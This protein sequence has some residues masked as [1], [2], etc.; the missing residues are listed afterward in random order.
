MSMSTGDVRRPSAGKSTKATAAD[1]RKPKDEADPTAEETSG[2]GEDATGE[3]GAGE[4][5]TG[6]K[7][8]GAKTTAAK[9]TAAKATA[10]RTAGA[11]ATPKAAAKTAP[12]KTA[13]AKAASARSAPDQA[14][15]A[16]AS[17]AGT[18]TKSAAPSKAGASS[19]PAV[20][21]KAGGRPPAKGAGGRGRRPVAPVKVHSERNW[22]PI[23]LFAGAGVVAVLI[24]GFAVVQL[25]R[26]SNQPTW[27]EKAAGIE[28]LVN[29]YETDPPVVQLK[30]HQAGSLTYK[31][32]PPAA[33]NHNARWQN[34]MG[35]VYTSQIAKEHAVH[36]LEHGAVWIAY[37][38]DL[39][40]NEIE[41]LASKVRD[42]EFMLMS[43]Y[44]GLDKPISLQAWGYQLKVDQADDGRVDAFIDALR[45]N[46]TLEPQA[47]CSGG[48]TDANPTPF[49]LPNPP[50]PGS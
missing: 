8:A 38:P 49:D 3:S 20:K 47:G 32:N 17:K 34:C 36:S 25:Y 40:Q 28:G 11:K 46:A 5:A 27:Q 44:P 19:R 13:P 48:I 10:T 50:A 12:A 2:T 1:I 35:D 14:A 41:A 18:P 43:P 37:R 23:A 24:I 42:R 9:T 21:A 39:P 31:M 16:K 26:Q 15:P 22:G 29:Y 4:N 45:K 33:G 7:A 6:G 30:E